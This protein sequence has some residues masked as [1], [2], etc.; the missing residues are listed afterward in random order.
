MFVQV[1]QN[2]FWNCVIAENDYKSLA[3]SLVTFVANISNTFYAAIFNEFG[4]LAPSYLGLLGME[5]Q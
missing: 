3:K 5:V 4:V 1:V 2:N